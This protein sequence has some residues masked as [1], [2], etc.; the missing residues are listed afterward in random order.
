VF[1]AVILLGGYAIVQT[2]IDKDENSVSIKVGKPV[3]DFR[4]S[5]LAG[6]PVSLADFEGKPLVINF[7]G[8][9]CEPCVRE[10]PVIE[11]QYQQWKDKDVQFLAINLSEDLLTV[12]NYVRKL[13]VTFPVIRDADRKVE[14]KFKLRSY[15]T[16]F[17]V[18]PD[19]TLHDV[20]VGEMNEAILQNKINALV[21]K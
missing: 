21:H 18:N 4:L 6:N 11:E 19:G 13:N 8:T 7:W 15:P 2:F 14:R 17:F 9:F 5:D 3:P 20:A 1:F 16:T 10:M 12:S